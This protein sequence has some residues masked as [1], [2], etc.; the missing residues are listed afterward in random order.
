MTK[1]LYFH[2][3]RCSKS[4]EALA[5]LHEKNIDVE[6]IDYLKN[7]PEREMLERIYNGLGEQ[8]SELIRTKEDDYP[9]SGLTQTASREAVL[10]ALLAYPKLMERPI[11][12]MGAKAVI[13][14]PMTRILDLF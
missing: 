11:I 7:P 13:G 3:P 1:A 4:R 9:L 2:N 6:V 12:L 10:N 5:A 14:R 8:V